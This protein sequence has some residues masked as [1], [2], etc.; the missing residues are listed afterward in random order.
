MTNSKNR[1]TI[2]GTKMM[3]TSNGLRT[4]AYVQCSCKSSPFWTTI[5]EIKRGSKLS[6][7]CLERE[8]RIKHGQHNTKLY[9]RLA[10]IKSRC[11]YKGNT[12]FANYGGKGINMYDEWV[13]NYVCF[14]NYMINIVG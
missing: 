10:N 14:A 5:K 9:K 12:S 4:F 7:G 1:L 6:C 13:N 8:N 3:Q 11:T 2:L